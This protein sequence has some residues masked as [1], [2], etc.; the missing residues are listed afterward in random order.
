MK[1]GVEQDKLCNF[2]IQS[3]GK[4][5]ETQEVTEGREGALF[6]ERGPERDMES[7]QNKI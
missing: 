1:V 4:N 3:T 6:I 5:L 7:P 2:A